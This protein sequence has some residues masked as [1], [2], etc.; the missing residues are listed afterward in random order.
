MSIMGLLRWC[1]AGFMHAV[2]VHLT[3]CHNEH[4]LLSQ[5]L[6][7]LPAI[8]PHRPPGAR[9][10]RHALLRH[11]RRRQMPGCRRLCNI[12]EATFEF[13]LNHTCLYITYLIKIGFT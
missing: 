12:S 10:S 2:H 6:T 11:C 13:K 8:A 4:A 3:R 1:S 7:A 9:P 5:P